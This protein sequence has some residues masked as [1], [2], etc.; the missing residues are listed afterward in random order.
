METFHNKNYVVEN[1]E[2]CD[3]LWTITTRLAARAG[4]K[5][6]RQPGWGFGGDQAIY[7]RSIKIVSEKQVVF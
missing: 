3:V 2:V 4:G 5:D 7:N 1:V 6:G